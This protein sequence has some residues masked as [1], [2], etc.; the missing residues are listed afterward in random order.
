MTPTQFW[1]A[2]WTERARSAYALTFGASLIAAAVSTL[3]GLIIAWVL[4]RYDFYLKRLL[5]A[6]IDLP[7]A[8]PTAVAGLVYSSQSGSGIA[9]SSIKTTTSPLACAIPILRETEMLLA[10]VL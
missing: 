7:F 6:L 5:D 10:S 4:V 3:F 9:S 1:N 2:V 8:L